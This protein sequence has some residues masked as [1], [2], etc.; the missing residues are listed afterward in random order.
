MRVTCS[1][2]GHLCQTLG[3]EDVPLELPGGARLIDAVRSMAEH[4]G[5]D[6]HNLLLDSD[7]AVRPGLLLVLNDEMVRRPDRTLKDGDQ[8]TVLSVIAGG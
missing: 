8:V 3:D 4:F 1:A 2:Y 6:A 5:E 7:D